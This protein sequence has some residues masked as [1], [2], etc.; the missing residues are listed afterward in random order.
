MCLIF[1]ILKNKASIIFF[2]IVTLSQTERGFLKTLSCISL[3]K[4]EKE[5][6]RKKEKKSQHFVSNASS[7]P[8]SS[9]AS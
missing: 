3:Q 6:K 1:H 7:N 8:C 5:K 4:K 2:L 9:C